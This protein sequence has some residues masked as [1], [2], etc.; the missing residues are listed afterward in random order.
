[1]NTPT[2]ID[3]I[4]KVHSLNCSIWINTALSNGVHVRVQQCVGPTTEDRLTLLE[5]LY[6]LDDCTR[7]MADLDNVVLVDV[8][9]ELDALMPNS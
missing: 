7:L 2:W 8:Q 5:S 1:M 9:A 4:N 6:R 3:V